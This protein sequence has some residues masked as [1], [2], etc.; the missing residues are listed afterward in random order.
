MK[1]N[2][3]DRAKVVARVQLYVEERS[4]HRNL[5]TRIRWRQ[6]GIWCLY[7]H[8]GFYTPALIGVFGQSRVQVY[9]DLRAARFFVDKQ[10]SFK[11]D[12]EALKQFVAKS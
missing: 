4:C 12:V 3:T 2:T 11:A 7:N 8:Y 5:A 10:P 1:H 6:V 9:R